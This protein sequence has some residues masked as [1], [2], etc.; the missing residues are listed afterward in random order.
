MAV[1]ALNIRETRRYAKRLAD[2]FLCRQRPQS[3]KLAFERI[4]QVYSWKTI[5][6]QMCNLPLVGSTEK[7]SA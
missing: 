5:Q 6:M 3:P 4:D 2:R 7:T 1:G